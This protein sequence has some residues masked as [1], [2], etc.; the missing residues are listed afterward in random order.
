VLM[1]RS[2]ARKVRRAGHAFGVATLLASAANGD[3]VTKTYQDPAFAG[4]AAKILVVGVHDDG[5][6]RGQFENAVARALR[7]AG[8]AGESSLSVG[9]ASQLSAATVVEAARRA[10]AD[11]VLVT[12]VADVETEGGGDGATVTEYFNA[13]ARY[14]D[15]L[16]I[17]TAHTVRVQ[18]ALYVVEGERRVWAAESTAVDKVDLFGVI[19][20]IATA[21]TLQLRADGLIR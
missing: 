6:V 10:R 21:L 12:Q 7:A 1:S 3:E 8:A 4:R 14:Q 18:S 19:D 2:F 11:A 15:P 17:T 16:P 20:G 9:G 5:S 13:Y